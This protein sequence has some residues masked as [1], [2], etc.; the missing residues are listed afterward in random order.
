MAAL[1]YG[2]SSFKRRNSDHRHGF[3][4]FYKD[5]RAT[6]VSEC[7]IPF[8]QGEVEGVENPGVMLVLDVEVGEEQQRVCVAT[9]H[10]PCS[11]TQCGL[12][13]LGQVMALLAAAR[14]LVEDNW[15][16]PF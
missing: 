12:K 8:P 15:S 6:L 11:D 2:G 4:I 7:P 3:A 5:N 16:M 14:V 1:G 9:T 10:I 13:R